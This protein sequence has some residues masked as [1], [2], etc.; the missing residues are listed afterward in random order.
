MAMAEYDT[1]T[2]TTNGFVMAYNGSTWSQLGGA[3]DQTPGEHSI[4]RSIAVDEQDRPVVAFAEAG[5]LYIQR[6]EGAAFQELAGLPTV[7]DDI[8]SDARVV[9]DACGIVVAIADNS[10]AQRVLSVWRY[11]N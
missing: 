5:Q 10:G 6:L 3:L 1:N 2:S 11:R 9:G 8:F 4:V 7:G